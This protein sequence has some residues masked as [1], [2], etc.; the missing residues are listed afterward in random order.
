[1]NRENDKR[2]E[3]IS[4]SEGES[5]LIIGIFFLLFS[6]ALL[7]I[8]IPSTIADTGEAFPNPRSL[9]Y[10]YGWSLL[11]LS[12]VEI[13][14]GAVK[15]KKTS[16]KEDKNSNYVTFKRNGLP[17]AVVCFLVI[18]VSVVLLKWLPYV[19]ITIGMLF[20][21]ILVIGNRKWP[22]MV[23]VSVIMPIAVYYF[24][25]MGLKLVLP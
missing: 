6:L 1:M 2:N 3:V 13:C 18:V 14:I 4:I 11:V 17:Q 19:P 16:L 23:I 22:V 5:E 10:V 25:T 20:L 9:P 21:L 8:M 15:C 24:F 7:F 12:V